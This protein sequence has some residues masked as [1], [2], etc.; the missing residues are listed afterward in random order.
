MFLNGCFTQAFQMPTFYVTYELCSRG[1]SQYLGSDSNSDDLQWQFTIVFIIFYHSLFWTWQIDSYYSNSC[2]HDAISAVQK[3]S[4][5][6]KNHIRYCRCNLQRKPNR[7]FFTLI[8]GNA[9]TQPWKMKTLK[10]RNHLV[11][12]NQ[13]DTAQCILWEM[14]ACLELLIKT[15]WI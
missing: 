4:H 3:S 10:T 11:S 13:A 14:S 8:I 15:S 1:E 9:V 7:A 12:S 5:Q 2:A 6:K